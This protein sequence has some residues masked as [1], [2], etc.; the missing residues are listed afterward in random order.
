LRLVQDAPELSMTVPAFDRD[1]SALIR[2]VFETP[3]FRA[4]LDGPVTAPPPRIATGFTPNLAGA[5]RARDAFF[6]L[7]N[8]RLTAQQRERMLPDA[9]LRL[10]FEHV[11]LNDAAPPVIMRGTDVVDLLAYWLMLAIDLSRPRRSS[12]LAEGDIFPA[13][14]AQILRGYAAAP[15]LTGLSADGRHD[16]AAWLFLNANALAVKMEL[17]GQ[18]NNNDGSS[19]AE[20]AI[21]SDIQAAL[22][23]LGL[24][25]DGLTLDREGLRRTRTQP[26]PLAR[27][28]IPAFDRDRAALLRALLG[29]P[30]FRA[31]LAGTAGATPA[32]MDTRFSL[33]LPRLRR[34]RDAFFGMA[35]RQLTAAERREMSPDDALGGAFDDMSVGGAT[36]RVVVRGTDVVDKL[37]QWISLAVAIAKPPVTPEPDG[38]EVYTALRAQVLRGYAGTPALA[39]LTRDGR[40]DLAAWLVMN[41]SFMLVTLMSSAFASTGGGVSPAEAALQGRL[42]TTL[43]EFGL[44]VAGVTL[45]ERGLRRGR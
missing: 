6:H 45:D 25:P 2:A 20:A 9:D 16:L 3:E 10:L 18:G 35:G 14:R 39:G 28:V 30:A 37:A 8:P 23:G 43:R 24:E 27:L 42:A 7:S 13:L 1:R 41:S 17:A 29:G 26:D 34:A 40:H 38:G 19:A 31:T 12:A 15:S 11:P 5:G 44:D 21:R 4:T 32:A 36:P 22:R 33:D